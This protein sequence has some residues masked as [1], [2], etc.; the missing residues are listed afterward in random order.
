M[1]SCLNIVFSQIQILVFHLRLAIF[2]VFPAGNVL[3]VE[4]Q[5]EGPNQ[6]LSALVATEHRM[7]WN[8][9]IPTSTVRPQSDPWKKVGVAARHNAQRQR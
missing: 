3:V 1:S 4:C 6:A 9:G 5:A 7:L 8:P 2:F